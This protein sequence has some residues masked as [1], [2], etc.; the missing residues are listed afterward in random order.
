MKKRT[1]F[2]LIELLVVVAIIAVLI[3]LLLPS[4]AK[5]RFQA[6]LLVCSSQLKQLG[7]ASNMYAQENSDRYPRDNYFNFPFIGSPGSQ[8]VGNQL[9]KY[10]GNQPTMFICHISPWSVDETYWWTKDI[11]NGSFSD[12]YLFYFYFGNYNQSNKF[13]W[14]TTNGPTGPS[15]DRAKLF[16]DLASPTHWGGVFNHG[17]ENGVN[18][19]YSDGSVIREPIDKLTL[20]TNAVGGTY[21]W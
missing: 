6:K 5:A 20:R 17:E 7:T 21:L 3:A 19:L 1:G 12:G 14:S 2:T 11:L 16:Q 9:I 18:S 15:S 10:L 4:L 8:F 13:S